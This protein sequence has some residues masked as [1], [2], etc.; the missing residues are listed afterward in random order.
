M[1]KIERKR[2]LGGGFAVSVE[3]DQEGGDVAEQLAIVDSDRTL[4]DFP[5]F[6]GYR[7]WRCRAVDL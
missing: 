5:G 1:Y 6:S 3:S 7:V 2:Q 4:G